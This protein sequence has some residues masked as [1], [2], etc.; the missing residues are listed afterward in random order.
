MSLRE[1][2]PK[3]NNKKSL[4]KK[5]TR[6]KNRSRAKTVKKDTRRKNSSRRNRSRRN[7]SRRNRSRRNRSHSKSKV[8][9]SGGFGL[10][11]FVSSLVVTLVLGLVGWGSIKTFGDLGGKIIEEQRK[12]G[13]NFNKM[14]FEK[15][16]SVSFVGEDK[17]PEEE[18]EDKQEDKPEEEQ[19]KESEGEQ[20]NPGE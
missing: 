11:E 4:K 18:K 6:R 2:K 20:N 14:L 15:K 8:N 3:R 5:D 17:T 7:R 16:K 1:S 19:K 9:Q 10:T 12:S 13:D